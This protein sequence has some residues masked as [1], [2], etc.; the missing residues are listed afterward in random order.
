MNP[1]EFKA[2]LAKAKA[3][4]H[5]ALGEVLEAI[6]ARL[7]DATRQLVGAKLR[8][9]VRTSDVLQTTYVDVVRS[10]QNFEGEDPATFASWVGRV[11]HRNVQDKAKYFNRQRRK[12]GTT[13]QNPEDVVEPRHDITPTR[14]IA[15][16]EQLHLITEALDSLEEDY[17]TVLRLRMLQGLDYKEVADRMGRKQGAVR[18]LFSRARAAFAMALDRLLN[19]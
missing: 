19:T 10:I 4:D 6:E 17:A 18:M 12:G 11:L 9:K 7:R 13:R 8:S 16:V 14:E 3:G 15:R 2:S 1:D 5:K